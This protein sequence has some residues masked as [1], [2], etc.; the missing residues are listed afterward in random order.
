[1]RTLKFPLALLGLAALLSIPFTGHTSGGGDDDDDRSVYTAVLGIESGIVGFPADAIFEEGAM[2]DGERHGVWSR[3]RADGAMRSQVTYEA[4]RPNGPYSLYD[5]L[6]NVMEEGNW[7]R[8]ANTG[9]LR[10]YFPNGTLR[11]IF[12]FDNI[13]KR[14]G[15]QRYY[16]DNGQLEMVVNMTHGAEEGDVVRMDRTGRVISRTSFRT[17]I[18]KAKS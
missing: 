1:M 9:E 13:G 11:Q 2:L 6:G 12:T 10:R 5:K 14:H 4:G 7:T 15:E 18:R 3:F 16:H 17:G 8:S